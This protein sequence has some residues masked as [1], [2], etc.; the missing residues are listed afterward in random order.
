MSSLSETEFLYD[1][2]E[3][4][5]GAQAAQDRLDYALGVFVEEFRTNALRNLDRV[6]HILGELPEGAADAPTLQ[7]IQAIL[8]NLAGQGSSFNFDLI[9]ELGEMTCAFLRGR[10]EGSSVQMALLSKVTE[11]M[12]LVLQQDVRGSGGLTERALVACLREAFAVD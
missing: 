7:S 4:D 12:R 8:S 9:S 11:A 5:A 2:N 3:G 6:D 1:S 10:I